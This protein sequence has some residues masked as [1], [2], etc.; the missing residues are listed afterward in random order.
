[1]QPTPDVDEFQSRT[2]IN[3]LVASTFVCGMLHSLIT[4]PASEFTW[5][6]GWRY[7]SRIHMIFFSMLCHIEIFSQFLGVYRYQKCL[8][9]SNKYIASDYIITLLE[10]LDHGITFPVRVFLWIIVGRPLSV[11]S[12]GVWRKLLN[13]DTQMTTQMT[14]TQVRKWITWTKKVWL[15]TRSLE[16]KWTLFNYSVL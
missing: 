15:L 12:L 10:L 7:P 16:S 14:G 8:E 5:N 2:L 13:V 4:G 3:Q 1:M 11:W 6:M 9:V